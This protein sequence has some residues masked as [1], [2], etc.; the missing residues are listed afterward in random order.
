MLDTILYRRFVLITALI[1][2]F[3]AIGANLI[4]ETRSP[5][6]YSQEWQ[7]PTARSGC[8]EMHKCEIFAKPAL[9][10]QIG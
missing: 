2:A 1:A 7:L 3:G 9:K 4:Q 5:R 10:L 6:V 8:A